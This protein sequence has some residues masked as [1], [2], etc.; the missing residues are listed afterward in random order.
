MTIVYRRFCEEDGFR[1]RHMRE[2]SG[3]GRAPPHARTAG[4]HLG[5]RAVEWPEGGGRSVRGDLYLWWS[6]SP[7]DEVHEV[8]SQAHEYQTFTWSYPLPCTG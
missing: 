4:V 2:A 7:E 6:C 3:G 1:V 5:K 8:S